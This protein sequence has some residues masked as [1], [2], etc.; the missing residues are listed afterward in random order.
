[1]KRIFAILMIA[2]VVFTFVACGETDEYEKKAVD[3][4]NTYYG[5]LC[6]TL[7][8]LYDYDEASHKQPK[9]SSVDF[10]KEGTYKVSGTISGRVDNGTIARSWDAEWSLTIIKTDSGEMK[11]G[12]NPDYGEM[13][14]K[15]E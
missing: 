1:M 10:V 4:V 14:F 11:V 9:V 15:A 12:S 7:E 6:T 8:G 5:A 3:A 2:V 13:K